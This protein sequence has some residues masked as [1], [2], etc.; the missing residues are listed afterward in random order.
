[1]VFSSLD[2]AFRALSSE[3]IYIIGGAEIYKQALDRNL[4]DRIYLTVI[5]GDFG[6]DA[7]FPEINEERWKVAREERGSVD[8]ENIYPHSFLVFERA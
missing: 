8:E 2:E 7:Y 3:D 4:A 1:M 5:E 6:G